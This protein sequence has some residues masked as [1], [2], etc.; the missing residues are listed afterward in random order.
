MRT[1]EVLFFTEKEEKFVDLLVM[2]GMKKNSAAILVYLSNVPKAASH[3]IERGTGLRQPEVSVAIR[4]LTD[5]GWV[6]SYEDHA[7]KSGRPAKIFMLSKPVSE[8]L[9]DFGDAKK[10]ETANAL[11]RVKKLRTYL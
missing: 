3:E 7:E 6:K 9:E 11:A 10:Q 4:F 1:E 5:R 8:I 2:L